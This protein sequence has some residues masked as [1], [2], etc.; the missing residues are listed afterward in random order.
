LFNII[1]N[2]ISS[3]YN[4][5]NQEIIWLDNFIDCP[6]F[7]TKKEIFVFGEKMAVQ[8]VLFSGNIKKFA[9]AKAENLKSS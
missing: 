8:L 5:N 7:L 1:F 2:K 9:H 6:W 4:Y 3:Y